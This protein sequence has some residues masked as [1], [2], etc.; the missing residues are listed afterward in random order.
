MPT[1]VNI[2]TLISSVKSTSESLEAEKINI[3]LAF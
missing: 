1:I 2:L 3:F